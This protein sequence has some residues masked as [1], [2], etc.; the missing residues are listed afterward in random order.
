MIVVF[1]GL[2]G[3]GKSTIAKRVAETV[4]FQYY[5]T[6]K[7][8]RE[9]AQEKGMT[10]EQFSKHAEGKPE[11]DQTLDKKIKKIAATK[12]KYIFDGQMPAY[13]LKDLSNFN[14][15]LRCDDNVRIERMRI[16]DGRDFE[17]QKRETISRETSERQRFIDLYGIDIVDPQQILT[18]YHFILDTTHLGMEEVFQ[19]CLDAV[20]G[21]IQSN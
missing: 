5:S 3:T 19:I 16:R 13:M 20:R 12:G 8:F 4:G 10:L 7:V 15:L 2:H 11:I 9:L 17:T 1:S 6:G 18:T 21:R 14:I